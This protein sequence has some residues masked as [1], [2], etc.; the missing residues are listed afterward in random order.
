M[1]GVGEGA[2]WVEGKKRWIES[3]DA[4]VAEA[5]SKAVVVALVLVLALVWVLVLLLG[6]GCWCLMLALVLVFHSAH[7]VYHRCCSI[8]FS[9]H[10][11]LH[12]CY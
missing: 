5:F 11:I 8:M 10:I 3:D 9:M 6:V 4:L 1:N 2:H 7:D 12:C